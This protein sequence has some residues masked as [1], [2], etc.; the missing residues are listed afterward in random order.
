MQDQDFA[1]IGVRLFTEGLVGGNFGNMSRREGDGFVITGTG[2]YLDEPGDLIFAAL[3][4][5]APTGASSEYRVHQAV[6]CLSSHRAIVHAHPPHAVAASLV[7]DR[8]IPRDSEGEMLCPAIPVV[9]G[10]PGTQELADS[11]AAALGE[12]HLAIARGHGTFAAGKNLEE[13]YLYTSLAEHACRVIA[14]S[15]FFGGC[16]C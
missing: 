10:A 1:R 2:A 9:G 13:A 12:G 3:E 5:P 8:V 7:L 4:G 16:N 11:V 14:Y 6:Y 15:G